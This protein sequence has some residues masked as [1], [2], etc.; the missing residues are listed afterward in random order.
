[1]TG[2]VSASTAL[3]GGMVGVIGVLMVLYL[4]SI[5]LY[6]RS[7]AERMDRQDVQLDKHE[8]KID[9]TADSL[10]A[11]YTRL[12][13][14]RTD[15]SQNYVSAENFLRETGYTR[16][17]LNEVTTGLANLD[18]K[19]T[20]VEHLPEISGDIARQVVREMKGNSDG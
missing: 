6:L 5:K 14:C 8:K 2:D 1:M 12:A 11:L 3:I 7:F 18:G 10:K 9:V 15:C 4:R 13:E 16:R 17:A 20:V 19:L